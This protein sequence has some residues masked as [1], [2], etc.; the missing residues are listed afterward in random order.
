M[1]PPLIL[2]FAVSAALA[3]APASRAGEP[4]AARA[5]AP[6]ASAPAAP[7]DKRLGRSCGSR[8]QSTC[9]RGNFC[10]FPESAECGDTDRPGVC[11][12]RPK[13]CPADDRPVCGCDGRTWP[14]ACRAHARGTS[15]RAQGACAEEAEVDEEEEPPPPP[16]ASKAP[17]K[18]P[19]SP[20]G[21]CPS[22]T[23][24]KLVQVQCIRAP[25]PPIPECV[26]EGK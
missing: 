5:K 21:E 22:G 13:L 18:Q 1:R 12:K 15:V 6:G 19:A 2:L 23:S 9:G 10:D 7:A 16:K 20:C 8:G 25:C 4:A 11:A 14:N 26:R 3:P 24:C 17:P